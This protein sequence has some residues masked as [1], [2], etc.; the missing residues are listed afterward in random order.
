MPTII[1]NT[2]SSIYIAILLTLIMAPNLAFAMEH[3]H[4]I[5]YQSTDIVI[6]DP[7]V[8]SAP[9]NAPMLG[10]FMQIRNKTHHDIKLLSAQ[11]K[12]Y[13]RVELHR[14]INQSGVMKMLKQD[15]MLINT[16]H[17]LDLKPGSWHIMLIG[18]EL[19][20]MQGDKV[21]IK[22]SFDNGLTQSIH[23]PVRKDQAITNNNHHTH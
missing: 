12:G 23:A 8:R 6:H 16:N 15:F 5:S 7:W 11:A 10:L 13:Q 17:Y 21:M 1:R 3:N 4:S 20:P 9:P 22:L 14:T 19:V 2:F 18:P